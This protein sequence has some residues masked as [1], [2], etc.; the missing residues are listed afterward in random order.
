VRIVRFQH[1]DG[2][3]SG[4]IC[5][6]FVRVW[7]GYPG[8]EGK[9]TAKTFEVHEVSFLP[10]VEAGKIIGVAIN[11]PGATGAELGISEPLV[12]FKSNEGVLGDGSSFVVSEYNKKRNIWCEPELAIVI[13]DRLKDCTTQEARSGILGYTIGN[14]ITMETEAGVDHH[15]ARAKGGDGFCVLGPFIDTKYIA[16]DQVIEGHHNEQLCR[17]SSIDKRVVS[18]PELL[19]WLSRWITLQP[20][21]VILT[22][23]PTRVCPR[24]YLKDGDTYRCMIDG[25]E[26]QQIHAKWQ[27]G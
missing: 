10:P 17:K 18:E 12:F 1:K 21:D 25:L 5:G 3:Y 15:L 27:C 6:D 26:S 11:Y 16:S 14:D 24:T 2:S 22:G 8:I 19:V 4:E 20:L 7:D 13:K 9:P 23:A